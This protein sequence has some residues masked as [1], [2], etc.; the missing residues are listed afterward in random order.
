MLARTISNNSLKQVKCV[1]DDLVSNVVKKQRRVTW[2]KNGVSK[3]STFQIEPWRKLVAPPVSKIKRA[4]KEEAVPFILPLSEPQKIP[5]EE[6]PLE[7]QLWNDWHYNT[8]LQQN[9]TRE[10]IQQEQPTLPR[11]ENITLIDIYQ[12]VNELNIIDNYE[13]FIYDTSQ[14]LQLGNNR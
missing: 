13:K 8:Y 2:L 9:N 12:I 4:N 5:I 14:E 7:E 10:E 3:V 1:L 11:N 6:Q